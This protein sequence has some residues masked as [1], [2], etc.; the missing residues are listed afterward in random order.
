LKFPVWGCWYI[1]PG[2]LSVAPS[3]W[4]NH[5]FVSMLQFSL[6]TKHISYFG[7]EQVSLVR[8]QAKSLLMHQVVS[9]GCC[10]GKCSNTCMCMV[11]EITY[12]WFCMCLTVCHCLRDKVCCFYENI[13]QHF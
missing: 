13:I 6:Y 1:F 8:I 9:D 11:W 12:N 3:I 7:F 10:H 5:N 4:R 2:L